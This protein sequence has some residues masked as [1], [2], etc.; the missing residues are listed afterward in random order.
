MIDWGLVSGLVLHTSCHGPH[1]DDDWR[2]RSQTV[3]LGVLVLFGLCPSLGMMLFDLMLH[4]VDTATDR[5]AGQCRAVSL[6]SLC[7]L[8]PSCCSRLERH[9][10]HLGKLMAVLGLGGCR[11]ISLTK[12]RILRPMQL[13]FSRIRRGLHHETLP[14]SH[15]YIQS[16]TIE[17]A[18]STYAIQMMSYGLN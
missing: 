2:A 8:A 16:G 9:H 18:K 4:H 10:F 6:A 7:T 17:L 15:Q 14:H 3:G 13:F 12:A 1:G 5:L 11:C